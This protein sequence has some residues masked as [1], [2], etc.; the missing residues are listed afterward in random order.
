MPSA[1][2]RF[3]SHNHFEDISVVLRRLFDGLFLFVP[4]D[5]AIAAVSVGV[6]LEQL[7]VPV[8]HKVDAAFLHDRKHLFRYVPRKRVLQYRAAIRRQSIRAP[9]LD[10]MGLFSPA[11]SA[12]VRTDSKL[13]PLA[14]TSKRPFPRTRATPL[15]PF[16]D[17]LVAAQ[18]R[19]VQ[20]HRDQPNAHM[21]YSSPIP[22][23]GR[24]NIPEV[25]PHG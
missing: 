24:A 4:V 12:S 5:A 22:F 25:S 6:V 16:G 9:L 11:S 10:M 20:I 7:S 3:S 18:Q 19:A 2:V 21:F 1:S 15:I 13:R 23:S 8:A 14:S 17:V